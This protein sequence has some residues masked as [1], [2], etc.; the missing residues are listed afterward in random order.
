M[1]DRPSSIIIL[2]KINKDNIIVSVCINCDWVDRYYRNTYSIGTKLNLEIIQRSKTITY[3]A[4]MKIQSAPI[5]ALRQGSTIEWDTYSGTFEE[6]YQMVPV[7]RKMGKERVS[8]FGKKQT[9]TKVIGLPLDN[10][11]EVQDSPYEVL[12]NNEE[13]AEYNET[14]K[15]STIFKKGKK[16]KKLGYNA[17]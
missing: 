2:L 16:K 7:R 17:T 11:L 8:S 15:L 5:L 10:V 9:L 13:T 14:L 4:T 6:E 1:T 12:S 3:H